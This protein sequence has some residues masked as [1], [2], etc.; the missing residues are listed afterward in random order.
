M[1]PPIGAILNAA[2]AIAKD[3]APLALAAVPTSGERAE[4]DALHGERGWYRDETGKRHYGRHGGELDRLAG[5][6]GGMSAG[7]RQA[8]LA[9][10]NGQQLAAQRSAEAQLSRGAGQG[11]STGMQAEAQRDLMGASQD[12]RLQAASGVRQADLASA[13]QQRAELDARRQAEMQRQLNRRANES[14]AITG[15]AATPGSPGTPGTNFA[16]SKA[17]TERLGEAMSAPTAA[18]LGG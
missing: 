15:T 13:A 7:E 14:R 5:G 8:M 2:G 6:A 17:A 16:A 10:A 12:A 18:R 11:F 9:E 3:S 1:P 4:T